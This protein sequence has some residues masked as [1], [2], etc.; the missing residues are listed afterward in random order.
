MRAFIAVDVNPTGEMLQFMEAVGKAGKVKMVERENLHLTLKFLG[1]VS[2]AMAEE[3]RSI[4]GECVSR[5]TAFDISFMG[6]GFF[7]PRG[8]PRV[9]WIGVESPKFIELAKDIDNALSKMG[10]E[11]E[12]SYV[13]HL[14]V[15]RVKGLFNP[16]AI[17]ERFAGMNFGTQRAACVKL[18]RSRLTPTGPIYSDIAVFH[19]R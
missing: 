2:E 6:Y 3:I 4:V 7:P 13:P 12:R 1:D 15:A 16:G 11:R 14:T 8:R 17:P 5:H 10:Y 9:V 18:K 19:L